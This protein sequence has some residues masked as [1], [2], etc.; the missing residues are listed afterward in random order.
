M[1]RKHT[2][3]EV[4]KSLRQKNDVKVNGTSIYLL[5]RK[6]LNKESILIDNPLAKNDIGNGTHG[7]I[8]FLVNHC[9]YSKTKVDKF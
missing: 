8:D 5:K 1:A 7:K 2:E 3:D 4:L 6:V 9:G